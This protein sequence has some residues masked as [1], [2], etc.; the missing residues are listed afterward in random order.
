M[1]IDLQSFI[2]GIGLVLLIALVAGSIITLVKVMRLQKQFNNYFFG[3]QQQIDE[4]R[5]DRNLLDEDTARKIGDVYKDMDSRLDKQYSKII[6]E[7][8]PN[9]SFL[10]TISNYKPPVDNGVPVP[11]EL[12]AA[13]RIMDKLDN[14]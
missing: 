13:K 4:I 10:Q 6:K 2:L 9:K 1:T 7:V 11:D 8:I 5:K 12:K 3:F 14:I